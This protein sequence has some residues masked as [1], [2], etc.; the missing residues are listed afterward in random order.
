MYK[1]RAEH[2]FL[3]IEIGYVLFVLMIL[4]TVAW[5]LT[6]YVVNHCQKTIILY[7]ALFVAESKNKKL[8]SELKTK[9]QAVWQEAC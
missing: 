6:I 5:Q 3:L 4:M 8:K 7:D 9:M 2:G 1:K